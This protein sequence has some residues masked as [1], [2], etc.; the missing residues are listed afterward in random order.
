MEKPSP[1]QDTDSMLTAAL[2]YADRGW[3]VFPN[4]KPTIAPNGTVTCSC[5]DSEDCPERHR[6]KHPR[7][8]A[9]QRKATTSPAQLRRWWK[10]HPGTNIGIATGWD[11]DLI[12]LDV[13]IGQGFQHLQAWENEGK[14]LP[15]TVTVKTGS[16]GH[17][18]YFRFPD[19]DFDPKT[20]AQL[21]GCKDIDVRAD[22]GQVVAPPSLHPSGN[23]YQWVDGRS[24]GEVPVANPPDW[25]IA[26]LRKD[27]R[28]RTETRL[29][30]A[31]S[32]NEEVPPPTAHVEC[33]HPNLNPR[34]VSTKDGH[35][36]RGLD[37]YLRKHWRTNPEDFGVERHII[38][39]L[40]DLWLPPEVRPRLMDDG[41]TLEVDGEILDYQEMRPGHVRPQNVAGGRW[42][43]D[44]KHNFRGRPIT[45]IAQTLRLL[46]GRVRLLVPWDY[47][48]NKWGDRIERQR[49]DTL[50]VP[51]T[52]LTLERNPVDLWA[53]DAETRK[54]LVQPLARQV[55][56][57]SEA[58]AT[59]LQVSYWA[60][61]ESEIWIAIHAVD[62]QPKDELIVLHQTIIDL[63]REAAPS[64]PFGRESHSGWD[65]PETPTVIYEIGLG[66]LDS[67]PC[68]IPFSFH[69]EHPD[70]MM[71]AFDAE[72]GE[73]YA[74]QASHLLS[75]RRQPGLGSILNIL[76]ALETPAGRALSARQRVLSALGLSGGNDQYV[77]VLVRPLTTPEEVRDDWYAYVDWRD[78]QEE[79][80]TV[81]KDGEKKTSHVMAPIVANDAPID[82][83][84]IGQETDPAQLSSERESK[85]ISEDNGNAHAAGVGESTIEIPPTITTS[86]PNAVVHTFGPDRWRSRLPETIP[87]LH[88]TVICQGFLGRIL[89]VMR[90][91]GSLD[92]AVAG[93]GVLLE[94]EDELLRRYTKNVS[95]TT[96]RKELRDSIRSSVADPEKL[97]DGGIK[98]SQPQ[99]D[100]C[101]RL[102]E[103]IHSQLS[104]RGSGERPSVEKIAALL[105][106]LVIKSGFQR[107]ADWTLD[108]IAVKAGWGVDIGVGVSRISPADRNHISR[109]M[110]R[111][112][113][114]YW[115]DVSG[116]IEKDSKPPLLPLIRCDR[117][118]HQGIAS[119]YV[120]LWENWGED[121]SDLCQTPCPCR[122]SEPMT[123]KELIEAGVLERRSAK[124]TARWQ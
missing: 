60:E 8:G 25:L 108:F 13:D 90:D 43:S 120:F 109:F 103:F 99:Q 15:K 38:A 64:N 14:F 84:T 111:I 39:A 6:G 31:D 44:G 82:A 54:R 49:L 96:T 63:L 95:E 27:G 16:G 121:F 117:K 47:R 98:L 26:M 101:H 93:E 112:C 74:D 70:R 86:P 102:S 10:E 18:F 77:D 11:S 40:G 61:G 22:G 23:Q 124:S 118:G 66:N 21:C 50:L 42:T 92:G 105:Q 97:Y 30:R 33:L 116:K 69:P 20:K 72:T 56:M 57:I 88:S 52:V 85:T 65:M 29:A 19:L 115:R 75:L 36:R 114:D 76:P 107:Q 67:T 100:Q 2:L 80:Q 32:S 48:V 91:E 113:E 73:F 53:G 59:P 81:A 123:D 1:D 24:P 79:S 122:P 28:P 106:A 41:L 55:T 12:V 119:R 5:K 34:L 71:M 17:Q 89:A 51:V 62:E 4:H 68:P 46:L 9:W 35:T 83:L 94:L 37:G 45:E 58:A 104:T 3:R 110:R 7:I 87:S 78:G